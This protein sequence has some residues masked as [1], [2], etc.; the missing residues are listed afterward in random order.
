MFFCF[1]LGISYCVLTVLL[2]AT[3]VESQLV[4][5]RVEE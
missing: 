3:M 1:V 5:R 4:R 2:M